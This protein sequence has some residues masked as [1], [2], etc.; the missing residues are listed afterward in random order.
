MAALEKWVNPSVSPGGAGTE[1]DPYDSQADVS[2]LG[3]DLTDAGG[4][5]LKVYCLN[6]TD[7]T[8]DST[9]PDWA[10]WI[11]D[12]T[13]FITIYQD[14]SNRHAGF[15]DN[16][17]YYMNNIAVGA[18]NPRADYMVHDG[19]QVNQ[20]INNRPVIGNGEPYTGI[21]I[22]NCLGKGAV[23]STGAQNG[24][25]FPDSGNT[26]V[27][28]KN[29]IITGVDGTG[30]GLYARGSSGANTI[31]ANNTILSAGTL[32]LG[33]RARGG[34][35]I[36][37]NNACFGVDTTPVTLGEL[38]ASSGYNA[39][40]VAGSSNF[41]GATG[42]LQNNVNL[43]GGAVTDHWT[44]A[45]NANPVSGS[46]LE[47]AGIGTSNSN[48]PS[49]DALGN[50]RGSTSCTL[51]AI[52]IP[53]GGIAGSLL[54][55]AQSTAA[56]S[57]R[58]T[59]GASITAGANAA[60][61]AGSII[62]ANAAITEGTQ[63]SD[64]QNKTI[65]AL[66]SIVIGGTSDAVL[67]TLA[68]A[69]AALVA[70]AQANES[71]VS[72][73]AGALTGAITENTV[74]AQSFIAAAKTYGAMTGAAN[75][76]EAIVAILTVLTNLASTAQSGAT[77]DGSI[78]LTTGTILD[79]INAAIIISAST[80]A[81]ESIAA[82]ALAGATFAIAGTI[83]YLIG[84]ITLQAALAA[85]LADESITPAIDAAITLNTKINGSTKLN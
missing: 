58:V 76:S 30:Y 81:N 49:T 41:G 7:T 39:A 22:L 50:P 69:S 64:T 33:M 79:S 16:S 31:A 25:Y 36:M 12:V 74:A 71:W 57:S 48:V 28:L 68:Q 56:M 60:D 40:E 65:S 67:D 14:D 29:N 15:F 72:E 32:D 84:A 52:E 6:N 18:L 20:T 35:V 9:F 83:G 5:T 77:F 63:A 53:A 78:S 54:S 34:F 80:S 10:A 21:E 55:A 47:T 13:N 23:S 24:L 11:C 37:L 26:N 70:G 46:S 8:G 38:V 66:T 4:D 73:I 59:L 44:S 61:I 3:W 19:I 75:T 62:Q 43:T 82:A 42:G 45:L 27:L 17:K 1:L 51:G 85:T 2:V